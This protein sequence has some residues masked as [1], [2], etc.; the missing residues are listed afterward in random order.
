[1]PAN[2]SSSPL[3]IAGSLGW[4]GA[5]VLWFVQA[6]VPWTASGTLSHSSTIDAAS[7]IRS[8]AVG[9]LAPSI[10][11]WLLLVLPA[12]GLALFASAISH[13][14]ATRAFRIVSAVIGL[15]ITAALTHYLTHFQISN[16]GPGAL[17]AWLGC[18]ACVINIVASLRIHPR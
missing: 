16:F 15:A 4:F 17:L 6:F 1:M 5:G 13:A 14:P 2:T 10:A 18:A 9:S 12:L 11:G 8:G 3:A 7:L